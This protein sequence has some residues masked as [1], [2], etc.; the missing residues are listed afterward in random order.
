VFD[1]EDIRTLLWMIGD[2]YADFGNKRMF[3]LFG[4]G[5]VGKSSTINIK[6]TA[7]GCGLTKIPTES[8]VRNLAAY[9]SK[10]V[11]AT[12]LLGAASS[13]VCT[14]ADIE[15]PQNNILNMQTVKALTG[16]DMAECGVRA[17]ITV[18]AMMNRLYVPNNMEDQAIRAD[19]ASMMFEI[20]KLGEIEI[21]R[22]HWGR[23]R[24]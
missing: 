23:R 2:M 4:P 8:V 10:N 24:I 20:V 9:T 3:I 5:G 22:S 16:N 12:T 21:R 15:V 7:L 6:A 19:M 11:G 17:N 14:T 13:R 1:K 18:V